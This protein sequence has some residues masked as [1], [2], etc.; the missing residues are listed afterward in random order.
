MINL[1]KVGLSALA[2]SQLQLLH[3]LVSSVYLVDMLLIQLV[4][5]ITQHKVL[6][7]RLT[8]YSMVQVN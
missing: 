2:G 8:D 3:K 7:V 6:V 5:L 4:R 1:R